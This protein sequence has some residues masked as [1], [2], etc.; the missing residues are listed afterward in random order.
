MLFHQWTEGY[1]ARWN[2][3]HQFLHVYGGVSQLQLRDPETL[4]SALL[5]E[6]LRGSLRH[7][8]QL[9]DALSQAKEFRR[10]IRDNWSFE[11]VPEFEDTAFS[12]LVSGED[13]LHW[14]VRWDQARADE[15]TVTTYYSDE[16][17][18]GGWVRGGNVGSLPEWAL[19]YFL[20]YLN[21]PPVAR[22]SNRRL[23][24][25]NSLDAVRDAF[26]I[27]VELETSV[28]ME[29]EQVLVYA[30]SMVHA[31]SGESAYVDLKLVAQDEAMM[32]QLDERVRALI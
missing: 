28:L 11:P 32:D 22:V 21:H 5:F 3:I 17:E 14:S 23:T 18:G 26:P 12:I 30:Q 16:L 19:S 27:V 13:D 10:V 29:D 4:E 6:N 9:L 15:P 2:A 1:E 20:N 31:G 8:A 24:P 25:S 7:W